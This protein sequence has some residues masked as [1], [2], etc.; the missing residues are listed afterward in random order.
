MQRADPRHYVG[1]GFENFSIVE[2]EYF[3]LGAVPTEAGTEADLNGGIN[4]LELG[5]SSPGRI[6]TKLAFRFS[7][8]DELLAEEHDHKID[9]MNSDALFDGVGEQ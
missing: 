7:L 3:I 5:V 2:G 9:R 6:H 8:V 1:K 4:P